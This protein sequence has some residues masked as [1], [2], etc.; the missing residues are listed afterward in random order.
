MKII[1]QFVNRPIIRIVIVAL[2]I[3]FSSST[4]L[5]FVE[6]GNSNPYYQNF[7]DLLVTWISIITTVGINLGP[8]T[9]DESKLLL[10]ISM[11]SGTFMYFA[12]FSEL[13]LWLRDRY[14]SKYKGIKRYTGA[15]HVIVVG[16]NNL[17][18]GIIHLLDRILLPEIDI[19]LVT[20][21]I[22]TNPDFERLKFIKDHP[23]TT[24]ALH[25]AKVES[26]ELAIIL[27][28][29]EVSGD[30]MDMNTVLIGGMI[31]ELNPDVFSIVELSSK[32]KTMT[33]EEFQIDETIT[34]DE[35]LE[36]TRHRDVKPNLLKKL[37]KNL[38]E[39]IIREEYR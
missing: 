32:R 25:K 27:S 3:S 22:D 23:A 28:N 12:A 13:I 15:N 18:L 16:Y 34:F 21:R 30:K 2:F 5:Y 31:E 37:P 19:V 1:I 35:L 7:P 14:E 26:A 20:S 4:L 17:A 33:I 24:T 39:I 11:L 6:K 38:R 36:D 9:S 29:D 10:V 8:L